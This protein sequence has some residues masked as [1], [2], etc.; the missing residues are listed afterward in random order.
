MV[1]GPSE[2]VAAQKSNLKFL[3]MKNPFVGLTPDS[4]ALLSSPNLTFKRIYAAF[5]SNDFSFIIDAKYV[6]LRSPLEPTNPGCLLTWYP[7][8]SPAVFAASFLLIA[9]LPSD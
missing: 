9:L 3:Y 1:I 7:L 4:A 5:E 8:S 6:N 2:E